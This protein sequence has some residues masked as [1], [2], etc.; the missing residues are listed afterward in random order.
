MG[1]TFKKHERLN[2][3]I[4]INDLFLKGKSFFKYPFKVVFL[5]KDV[6][7]GEF[8]AILISVSKRNFK[9]AVDR[10]RIKRLIREAYRLN[11]SILSQEESEGN[12]FRNF[13]L[14]YTAKSILPFEEIE[15]KIMLI[16]QTIKKQD[17]I[18]A[19]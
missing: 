14:I 17:E 4:Q 8:N 6:A 16:L 15:R 2:S 19:N 18:S 11:K 10:N 13:A 12:K 7:D 1:N 5:E 3:K 9:S